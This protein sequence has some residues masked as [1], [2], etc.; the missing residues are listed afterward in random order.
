[1]YIIYIIIIIYI[2]ILY[3]LLLLLLLLYIVPTLNK[4]SS[5]IMRNDVVELHNYRI[6][7]LVRLKS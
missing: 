4:E 1:M 3:I 5:I 6:I 2:Y 7:K